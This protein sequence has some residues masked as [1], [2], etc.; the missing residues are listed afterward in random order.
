MQTLSDNLLDF[1]TAVP[2]NS[3][4][5]SASGRE[6]QPFRLYSLNK[7][8][9][10]IYSIF[11]KSSKLSFQCTLAQSTIIIHSFLI[12]LFD[13]LPLFAG[14]IGFSHVAAI[15]LSKSYVFHVGLFS[16]SRFEL[17]ATT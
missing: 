2:I 10:E 5:N 14:L 13:V 4:H 9:V 11:F 3:S 16:F 1:S 6:E 15:E 8:S 7:F 12:E 17:H